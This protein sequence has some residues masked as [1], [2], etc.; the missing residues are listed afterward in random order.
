[1][2]SAGAD[3]TSSQFHDALKRWSDRLPRTQE[4]SSFQL[5]LNACF[6]ELIVGIL[7]SNDGGVFNRVARWASS[8]F[9]VMV[10][11][12]VSHLVKNFIISC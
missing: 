8:L 7:G 4:I 9:L 10:I 5:S 6:I 1:M 3:L 2:S 11:F 12:Y